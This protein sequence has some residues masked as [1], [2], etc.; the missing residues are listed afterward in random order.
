MRRASCRAPDLQVENLAD[1]T[2]P[3]S[4][5]PTICAALATPDKKYIEIE[6]ATYYYRNEPVELHQCITAVSNWSRCKRL[7][8]ERSVQDLMLDRGGTMRGSSY[9]SEASVTIARLPNADHF[10][11]HADDA[12]S[13]SAKDSGL[14]IDFW[15][16]GASPDAWSLV[17]PLIAEFGGFAPPP[18]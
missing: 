1:D 14:L 3:A 12:W 18:L 2:V 6:G 9:K 15:N 7:L 8:A 16:D 17:L 4:H 10:S 13:V 5:D 11:W